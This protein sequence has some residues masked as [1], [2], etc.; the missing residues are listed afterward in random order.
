MCFIKIPLN[1]NVLEMKTRVV[2][3]VLV[4]ILAGLILGGRW[5]EAGECDNPSGLTDVATIQRCIG[6][7]QSTYEAISKANTA[8]KKTLEDLQKRVESLK[9]SI[10][11]LEKNMGEKEKLIKQGE[12]AFA[13]QYTR[14]STVVRSYYIR[15]KAELGLVILV[16]GRDVQRTISALG[17]LSAVTRRDRETISGITESIKN[18]EHQ[19][20]ELVNQRS[21][22]EKV[23]ASVDGQAQFYASEVAKASDYE[24]NLNSKI[25]ALTARQNEILAAK[26]GTFQTSV[27]D[28][29]LA[30]DPNARPD[31]NP[32][33]S[34]AFAA[35][36]FGAPHYKGMSQYGAL[37][38]S[39]AGQSYEDI[40]KAYYGNVRVESV[41]TNFQI[42]TSS[43]SMQFEDR[44]IMGIAEM[45]AKWGNEGGM[46]ALKAQAIAARSYALAYT[47]WRMGNR[48]ASGSI[49]VTESC[50]VWKA[51]KADNPA[52]WR[53]AVEQTRGKILVSNSS[54]E[55][56]NSWYAS[57]SGGY[58]ESYT[59][60]G[61]TTPGFWDTPRGREGWTG[62]AY[63]K[64]GGSPW[65]Y[66]G[67]YKDRSGAGCGRNH[68]W[69]TSEQ[70][71]DI[72]NAWVVRYKGS[73]DEVGR[74]SPNDTGC[75]GGNPYS[76]SEMKE[77]AAKY[78]GGYGSV[79]GVSV[80]YATDGVTS[81]LMFETDLGSVTVSGSEFKTAF[82][83]RALGKISIKSGLFNIEKK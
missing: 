16:G 71:A 18:L 30:D 37:G 29:P 33:F 9:R 21:N 12:G 72:L 39:R 20:Q 10:A 2:T 17:L 4:A 65:F 50:Q 78:G 66:K 24:S 5:V 38:R 45:P 77:H 70:M 34:P 79:S 58:Q 54:N 13:T 83:L 31:Y 80:S 47:G 82:N 59:S 15:S 74:V 1:Y 53:S 51:S 41:D 42:R 55:V 22:L 43:G 56:V 11:T 44:Y 63:E 57:T 35:F 64:S 8:N 61:H 68:P 52:E 32:G 76:V 36:S 62:E 19:R 14:F 69:L 25:S 67:W 26:T 3:L 73:S 27:G 48:N 6:E 60:L 40:L 49:C 28:V 46:E 75:W 23:K 7:I 81:S